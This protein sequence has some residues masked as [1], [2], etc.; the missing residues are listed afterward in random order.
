MNANIFPIEIA[1]IVTGVIIYLCAFTALFKGQIVEFMKKRID[2]HEE[3]K[4]ELP[5]E[6]KEETPTEETEEGKES[7]E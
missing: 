1:N 2:K 5:V 7:E 6:E 4:T 3:V